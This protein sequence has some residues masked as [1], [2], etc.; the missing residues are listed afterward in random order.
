MKLTIS[1]FRCATIALNL[2]IAIGSVAIGSAIE[3]EN[4]LA[5]GAV[6]VEYAL[7]GLLG[8]P[9]FYFAVH[10]A[11]KLVAGIIE[12]AIAH[13]EY[14]PNPYAGMSIIQTH[15]FITDRLKTSDTLPKDYKGALDYMKERAE[16]DAAVSSNTK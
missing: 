11:M 6:P 1:K 13:S 9:F 14:H 2:V 7:M 15:Q 3:L 4:F 5:P 8:L 12:R 16:A 10:D